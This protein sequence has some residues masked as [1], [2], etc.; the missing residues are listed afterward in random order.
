MN[1]EFGEIESS[2]GTFG[3]KR[4]FKLAGVDQIIV[5]LWKVSDNET[6]ELMTLFYSE[7]AKTKDIDLSFN[8]AQR[9][10]RFR[11]PFEPEKWAGFVLVH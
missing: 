3:L 7:L 5:S 1:Y 4:G 8:K 11:Y 6:M 10:M 2:E 9:E